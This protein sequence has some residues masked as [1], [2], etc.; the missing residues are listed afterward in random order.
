MGHF[1]DGFMGQ[2]GG[3]ATCRGPATQ[4]WSQRPPGL[5][6]RGFDSAQLLVDAGAGSAMSADVRAAESHAAGLE[7]VPPIGGPTA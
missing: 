7:S 4:C 3:R 2:F 1:H 5:A 6:S